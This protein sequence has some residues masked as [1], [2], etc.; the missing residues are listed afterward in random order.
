MA[1]PQ[2]RSIDPGKF[3]ENVRKFVAPEA[4]PAMK[5]MVARGLVPMKP[6]VQVC[7]LFQLR[8]TGDD[9]VKQAAL[10]SVR[11]LPQATVVQVAAAPLLPVVLDWLAEIYSTNAEIL[12]TILL[13][14][15]TDSDTFVRVAKT[16]DEESCEVIARN[17]ARLLETPA[18][19]ESLY[20]NRNTRASTADRIID[21]AVRNGV[22]LSNLPCYEEI[23]A[24]IQGVSLEAQDT[25]ADAAF[26][27]AKQSLEA[28][29]NEEAE[30]LADRLL[31]EAE[32]AAEAEAEGQAPPPPKQEEEPTSK[33]A[34]G[35]IRNLNIAQKVRMAVMGGSAERAILINDSNKVV[36]RAV[37]RSP[38]VTDQEAM[39]FANNK[40]LSEEVVMFM[41]NQ[42]KW[43]RHYQMKLNLVNNPKTPVAYA[44]RFLAY[45]RPGDLKAVAKSKG[46]PGPVAKAA[47]QMIKARMK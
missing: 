16:A 4:P 34:A 28:L 43:T 45:L 27:E 15:Y 10:E 24:A 6:L 29:S 31:A 2:D 38:A 11:R 35:K 23:V 20:F 17:Q 5:L 41:C 18:I 26:R 40:A 47:K 39:R 44:M 14:K 30:A 21:F 22:D 3:P 33:S 42:R 36:S 13:N 19:I 25:A 32:A 8:Q 37:I 46:V 1:L 9:A 12:H 7:A